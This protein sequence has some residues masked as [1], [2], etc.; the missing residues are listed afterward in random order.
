M[1]RKLHI[2]ILHSLLQYF[3]AQQMVYIYI[4]YFYV[5]H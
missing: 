1:Y 2:I 4:V 3:E 5:L